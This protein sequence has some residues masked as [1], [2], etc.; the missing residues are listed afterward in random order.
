MEGFSEWCSILCGA[1]QSNLILKTP[2]FVGF[3]TKL[4]RESVTVSVTRL[5]VEN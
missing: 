4:P 2:V 3:I 1:S 5:A